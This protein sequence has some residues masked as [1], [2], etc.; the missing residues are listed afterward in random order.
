M[1]ADAKAVRAIGDQDAEYVLASME[2]LKGKAILYA[3]E[4]TGSMRSALDETDRR[5]SKQIEHNQA[6]GIT[7]QGI[8]KAVMDVM[9]AGYEDLRAQPAARVADDAPDY[10]RMPPQKLAKHL[11]LLEQQM[12]EAAQNLEFEQA[13]AKRDEIKRIREMTLELDQA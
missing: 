4:I 13:A 1:A 5:R 8:R 7:P 12:H 10:R 11:K 6:H 3:D 2:R 9:H